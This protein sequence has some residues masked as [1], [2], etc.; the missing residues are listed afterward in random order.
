MSQAMT[1]TPHPRLYIGSA[2][3]DRLG[4]TDGHELL[5]AAR[6]RVAEDAEGYLGDPDFPFNEHQHNSLL[7]RAR[8]MQRRMLTLLVRW[9]QSGEARYRDAAMRHVRQMDRWRYWSWIAMRRGEADPEAV[10]DL[11]YGENSATLAL[12][13][14][15]LHA[16]LSAEEAELFHDIAAR[17]ALR[18]YLVQTGAD[19]PPRW[20]ARA[21]SNWNSVCTGGAGM[22]ALAM[23]EEVEEAAEALSRTEH[24]IAPYMRTLESTGGA[25]PEGVGYWNYGM[26]YAFM[27]LLS[28]ERATGEAHPLMEQPATQATL[29]FPLDFAP[30]GVACSF[31]D[32]NRWKPIPIH[33][34]AAHRL[35]CDDLIAALDR[36]AVL[37]GHGNWPHPAEMLLL[38]PR[39]VP[40]AGEPPQR[41]V[42]RRYAGQDWCLLADR[43]PEP[44]LYASIRGGTTE[45]PHGHH[46]LM[47][48]NVLVGRERLLHNADVG[49]YL[50][51]TF[52]P[53]RYELLEVS[54]HAKNGLLINGVGIAAPSTVSTETFEA[55]AFKAVRLDGTEA[56]GVSRD[57]EPAAERC[58]RLIALLGDEV[59]LVLDRAELPHPGRLEARYHTPGAIALNADQEANGARITGESQQL[60][61]AFA[62]DVPASLHTA[63]AALTS[64]D[65][66]PPLHRLRWCTKELHTRMTMAGAFCPHDELTMTLAGDETTLR[67]TLDRAGRRQVVQ[68]DTA[69]REVSVSS[70]D[71]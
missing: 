66:A 69:L 33:Y 44:G 68:C 24:S 1:L 16:T 12:A 29:Q 20:F 53:R 40:E 67:V 45:V 42:L 22:L 8:L 6:Q 52:S 70:P 46:D 63:T 35:G 37:D 48:F 3:L 13:Y 49:E 30:H 57:H 41:R 17:R 31:G 47:S 4:Q 56:M 43:W 71:A 51:T 26:R 54:P 2:E 28:H 61:A 55:E 10:F 19:A 15:L 58:V 50:D 27:Y 64:P 7:I 59:I 32:V 36:C 38:H 25:W 14:T 62:C 9:W 39:T 34:A 18:P 11:S 60:H 23:H 21:D 5:A 65:L